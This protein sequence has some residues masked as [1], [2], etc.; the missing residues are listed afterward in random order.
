M[1]LSEHSTRK[2]FYP[3]CN[4]S[5]TDIKNPSQSD[6]IMTEPPSFAFKEVDDRNFSVD[7]TSLDTFCQTINT[8]TSPDLCARDSDGTKSISNTPK[9]EI[10]SSLKKLHCRP[11][12]VFDVREV[13]A[14]GG[15]SSPGRVLSSV[16]VLFS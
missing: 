3:S 9:V 10:A 7:D 5:T 11:P 13:I 4:T 1:L 12:A 15:G 16:R 6:K 8:E 14:G 2:R